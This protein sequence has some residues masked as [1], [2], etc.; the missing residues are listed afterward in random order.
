VTYFGNYP[1][2]EFWGWV[3]SVG[4]SAGSEVSLQSQ[5]WNISTWGASRF[6]LPT[7]RGQDYE[8]PFR[9]GQQWRSKY[10]NSRTCTLGMWTA[11]I[12]QLTG[13]PDSSGITQKLTFNNNLQQLRALF[14]Q[15]GAL[16]SLQSQLVRRWY[17]TQ[18][19]TPLV[20]VAKSMA[21][22]AGTMEPTM[23]G[24]L[25]ASFAV[26]LLLSDPYFYGA[27]QV[28]VLTT[29]GATITNPAEGVAGEGYPSAVDGFTLALTASPVTVTNVTAGVSVT[30]NGPITNSPVTLDILNYTAVDSAANNVIGNVSH[31]GARMWMCLVPG[32]N[33][34]TVSAGTAT[35]TWNPPYI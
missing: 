7:L 4:P 24:R 11:A 9:A 23:S 26:D 34:I 30:Y 18:A 17:I 2:D 10:P 22:I 3:P 16:G 33:V 1:Q 21:E 29:A 6:A 14:W 12:S 32:A 25:G 19:G 13:N 8:Q 27:Q 28:N 20:V 5:W 35:F 15:R 31:S